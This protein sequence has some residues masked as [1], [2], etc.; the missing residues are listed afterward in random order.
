MTPAEVASRLAGEP[1]YD[2][3]DEAKQQWFCGRVV[4]ICS[5]SSRA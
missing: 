5:R 4:D 1:T 2:K 3:W